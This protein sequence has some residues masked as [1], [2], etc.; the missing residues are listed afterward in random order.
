MRFAE[1]WEPLS[2]THCSLHVRRRCSD[3]GR[4]HAPHPH[5]PCFCP[6]ALRVEAKKCP[7]RRSKLAGA[8][9]W[10]N[11]TTPRVPAGRLRQQRCI[12]P[13]QLQLAPTS[14]FLHTLLPDHWQLFRASGRR[15]ERWLAIP[16]LEPICCSPWIQKSV[17]SRVTCRLGFTI[18]NRCM[19]VSRPS[20]LSVAQSLASARGCK[21][22]HAGQRCFSTTQLELDKTSAR[23]RAAGATLVSVRLLPA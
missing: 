10:P 2:A 3:R 18:K 11:T 20:H 21:T 14:S 23:E 9:G 5:P 4:A 7:R 12:W 1:P 6:W 19:M 17:R 22:W 8:I 13:E 15:T 16:R